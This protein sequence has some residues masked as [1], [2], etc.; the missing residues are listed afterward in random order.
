MGCVSQVRLFTPEEIANLKAE[1]RAYR[2]SPS[3]ADVGR[4]YEQYR[5]G[6]SFDEI[7]KLNRFYPSHILRAFQNAGL[8]VRD[9]YDSRRLCGSYRRRTR[10]P[11]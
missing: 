8:Q 2:R 4:L 7:A 5:Q 6:M 1:K 9:D 11:W 3:A 10:R